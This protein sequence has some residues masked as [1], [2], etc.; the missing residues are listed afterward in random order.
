[1]VKPVFSQDEIHRIYLEWMNEFDN[2][3]CRK[4]RFLQMLSQIPLD[5]QHEIEQFM[6]AALAIGLQNGY[7]ANTTVKYI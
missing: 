5:K 3:S 4:D 1:M 6:V 7:K 2:G